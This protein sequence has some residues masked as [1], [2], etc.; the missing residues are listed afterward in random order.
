MANPLPPKTDV[1]G[2]LGPD[3]TAALDA[4]TAREADFEALGLNALVVEDLQ[5]LQADTDALGKALVTLSST[6][7]QTSAQAAI[8]E[9]DAAFAS[10]IAVF[11]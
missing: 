9:V 6:D 5:G 8:T 3:I 4:L 11:S 7:V 2:T 1:T 10:A